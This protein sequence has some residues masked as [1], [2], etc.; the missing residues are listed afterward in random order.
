MTARSNGLRASAYAIL[1]EIEESLGDAMLTALAAR[2]IAAYVEPVAGPG[3]TTRLTLYVDVLQRAPAGVVLAGLTPAMAGDPPADG[4]RRRAVRPRR[5][6]CANSPT[7]RRDST[8]IR[9]TMTPRSPH[10][11]RRFTAHP[12]SAPGPKPKT[13]QRARLRCR[14]RSTRIGA[15]DRPA[16]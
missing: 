5:H 9:P 12:A 13:C 11:S 7:R 16:R 1:L 6:R 2:D 14:P 10:S 8:P 3:G 15:E 4:S